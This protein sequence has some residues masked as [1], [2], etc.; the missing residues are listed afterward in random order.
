MSRL[1]HVA[2]HEAI[3]VHDVDARPECFIIREDIGDE[4]CVKYVYDVWHG[5]NVVHSA[6]TIL[7]ASQWASENGFRIRHN[8]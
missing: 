4:D 7:D 5:D 8:I 2:S 1:A 6:R 3:V